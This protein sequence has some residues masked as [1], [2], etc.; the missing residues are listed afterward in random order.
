M[1][2]LFCIS[3]MQLYLKSAVTFIVK[4]QL[5]FPD[6]HDIV[7]H[8]FHFSFFLPFPTNGAGGHPPP[9]L[10]SPRHRFLTLQLLSGRAPCVMMIMQSVWQSQ[11][12]GAPMDGTAP[13]LQSWPQI[14]TSIPGS[15]TKMQ[16]H[17]PSWKSGEFDRPPHPSPLPTHSCPRL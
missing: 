16:P 5:V 3:K 12:A 17:A 4:L 11:G 15:P 2:D 8:T 6:E 13:H 7:V 14:T 9:K 10:T 1:H